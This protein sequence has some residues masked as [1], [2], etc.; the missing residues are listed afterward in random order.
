MDYIH[1][2]SHLLHNYVKLSVN[3]LDHS[4]QVM[5]ACIFRIDHPT[6]MKIDRTWTEMCLR[7]LQTRVSE[8]KSALLHPE[9]PFRIV[10]YT[11][12]SQPPSSDWEAVNPWTTR[13]SQVR[14]IHAHHYSENSNGFEMYLHYQ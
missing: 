6:T 11:M 12:D 14:S 13:T 2:C 7:N 8:D 5:D 3:L 9:T 10:M 4:L 1:K